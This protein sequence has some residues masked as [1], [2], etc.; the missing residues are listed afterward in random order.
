[1]TN[2]QFYLLISVLIG[3]SVMICIALEEIRKAIEGGNK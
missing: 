1:M 2:G 3:C